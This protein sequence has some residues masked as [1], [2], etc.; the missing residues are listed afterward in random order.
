VAHNI[1]TGVLGGHIDAS[2][3]PAGTTFTL[4]LPAAAPRRVPSDWQARYNAAN[5]F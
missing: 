3:S 1:V 2:S 5:V 4:L